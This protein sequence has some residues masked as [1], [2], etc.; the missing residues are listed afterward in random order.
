VN[1]GLLQNEE[2]ATECLR[3]FATVTT[4]Q[5]RVVAGGRDPY[6]TDEPIE[7]G[8]QRENREGGRFPGEHRLRVNSDLRPVRASK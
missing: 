8:Y 3:H 4:E 2:Q 7:L 5:G 6:A 1:L